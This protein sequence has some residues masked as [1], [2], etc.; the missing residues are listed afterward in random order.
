ME[1]SAEDPMT[2]KT[3][4]DETVNASRAKWRRMA[5]QQGTRITELE[6]MLAA[7]SE[8]LTR[9]RAENAKLR[10]YEALYADAREY[11]CSCNI[12]DKSKPIGDPLNYVCDWCEKNPEGADAPQVILDL[13]TTE[14]ELASV[15][16]ALM[17]IT[18]LSAPQPC[19]D[20][21]HEVLRI[22]RAALNP[23]TKP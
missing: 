11:I 14:R 8:E 21:V 18:D 17:K 15:K 2:E 4:S 13:W 16:E 9:L 22:S 20:F 23:E 19:S 5:V 6:S 7:Q 12:V 1:S 10:K 3:L